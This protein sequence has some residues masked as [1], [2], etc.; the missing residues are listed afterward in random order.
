MVKTVDGT[1]DSSSQVPINVKWGLENKHVLNILTAD[2]GGIPV[3]I[4]VE[5]HYMNID[6][7][8]RPYFIG[9]RISGWK[10]PSAKDGWVIIFL[11]NI[12]KCNI[13]K[14]KFKPRIESFFSFKKLKDDTFIRPSNFEMMVKD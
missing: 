10:P 5:P 14:D 6:W 3:T 1:Q 2:S 11:E 12:R 7:D 4:K 8:N 9:Q 13:L